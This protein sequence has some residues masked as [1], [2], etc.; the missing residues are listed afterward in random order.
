MDGWGSARTPAD[1]FRAPIVFE[2]LSSFDPPG[3]ARSD[4]GHRTM[5]RLAL[6]FLI[7]A[8]LSPPA[9]P[10]GCSES[11]TLQQVIAQMEERGQARSAMLAQYVCLRRYA[12]TNR[13]FHKTAELSVR[14]TYTSPG[15]KTFEV[16]SE[17]GLSI[18]RQRV[19]RKML[20]AEEEA[21]REGIRES[22]QISPRNYDFR[23]TGTQLQQGQPAYVLELTPRRVNKFLMR[24]RIW[25]DCEDFAI[26]R[27]EAAPAVTPS[28][29]IR[30]I[31]VVQ[32]YMKVGPVWLPLY[33]HSMSD[34]F[35]FGHT[36]VAIDS[37]DY[38][39]VQKK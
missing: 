23:L 22:T 33:N 13:R 17:R 27:V 15:H 38:E 7:S 8:V 28:V 20:E 12:L 34:S 31:H 25:V 24:G 3:V 9:R 1:Q 5:R 30:N 36:D 26:V 35:F 2:R 16:L 14:M 29:F 37:S 10:A 32:Q 21:S 4:R 39:I 6:F 11:P 19:L 18:I